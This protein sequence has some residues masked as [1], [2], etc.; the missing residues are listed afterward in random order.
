MILIVHGDGTAYIRRR[1]ADGRWHLY[2]QL[3]DGTYRHT[4]DPEGYATERDANIV[5]YRYCT[6]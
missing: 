5:A 3:S 1:M 4:G 6:A 2:Y